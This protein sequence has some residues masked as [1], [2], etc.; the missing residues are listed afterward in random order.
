MA[1]ASLLM[2]GL[3]IHV[4]SWGNYASEV[5]VLKFEEVTG[6]LSSEGYERLGFI[7]SDLGKLQCAIDAYKGMHRAAGD[8]QGFVDLGRLQLHIGKWKSAAASFAAYFKAGGYSYEA[9]LGYA[10]SLEL[11]AH[12]R[13]ARLYYQIAIDRSGETLPVRATS[14]LVHIL[15]REGKDTEALKRIDA[16]YASGNEAR[17]YL[18]TE[19]ELLSERIRER[20]QNLGRRDLASQKTASVTL[21]RKR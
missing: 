9:A 11:G 7:C 3:F 18:N 17:G 14:A 8:I 5:P 16:F 19:H 20:E 4:A 12:L 21:N 15:M 13:K 6:L 10:E 1:A 2:I